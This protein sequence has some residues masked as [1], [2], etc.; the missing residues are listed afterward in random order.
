MWQK[1]GWAVVLA[2]GDLTALDSAS[3]FYMIIKSDWKSKTQ[4]PTEESNVER[5]AKGGR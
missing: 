2:E 1:V 5:E 3:F 4:I